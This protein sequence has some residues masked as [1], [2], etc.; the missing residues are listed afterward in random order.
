MHTARRR[1]RR[2]FYPGRKLWRALAVQPACN[3]DVAARLYFLCALRHGCLY[4]NPCSAAADGRVHWRDPRCHA[5][6]E[7]GRNSPPCRVTSSGVRVRVAGYGPDLSIEDGRRGCEDGRVEAK[8]SAFLHESVVALVVALGI[9]WGRAWGR[10][11]A[12]SSRGFRVGRH[13][14]FCTYSSVCVTSTVQI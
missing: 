2:A 9:R 12:R 3:R 7:R 8:R 13:S 1:K 5:R 6:T 14:Q 4:A 11:V 10:P